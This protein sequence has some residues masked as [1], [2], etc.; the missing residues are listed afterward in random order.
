MPVDPAKLDIVFYPDPVLRRTAQEIESISEEVCA[1]A[2]R[3]IALMHAV[4]GVGLAAPQVGLPW[5][6]FVANPSLE[7]GEDRVF[8]NPVLREFSEVVESAEEGCLSL[9]EV[10]GEILRPVSVTIEAKGLDEEIFSMTSDALPARVWQHET[11]HLNGVLIIDKM[12]PM[13][14]LASRRKLKNLESQFAG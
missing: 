11:D 2:E 7:E 10:R 6:L 12:S 5:R 4:R 14:K 13:D 3:M 8:I 1:V 9:P